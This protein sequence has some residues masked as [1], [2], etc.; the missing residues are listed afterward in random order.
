MELRRLQLQNFRN[1]ASLDL[2][3]GAGMHV[4]AGANAQGKTN[5]LEAVYFAATGR[6]PRARHESE[7]IDW[8]ADTARVVADYLGAARGPFTVEAALGRR[9]AGQQGHQ[10]VRVQKKFRVNGVART[11]GDLAGLVP[12]VLF[13]VDDLE[14][15]RG[16]PA[17][18]REFLDTDLATMSRTYAWALRQ[19]TRVI[20]QRNKLLKDIREGSLCP[21]CLPAWNE[22]VA[23][24]GGRLL[25]VR[26]RFVRD[27]NSVTGETYQGLTASGQQMTLEYRREWGDPEETPETRADFTFLLAA[28]LAGAEKEEIARGSSLAGPHRDDLRILVDGRDLRQFGSQGEQRTAA[29]ALRVAEF[30]LQNRLLSEPPVLLLDDILSELDRTRRAALLAHLAPM[31]QVIV[32]TTDVDALGLPPHADVHQ[33]CVCGGGVVG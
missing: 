20:E 10:P 29:L 26:A 6:S 31:A 15:I 2:P 18:R 7:L 23:D 27:L 13:L 16:E 28:A 5:L 11:P 30:E 25:E 24:Y 8:G 12:V 1:Y 32:T 22:Q 33:Y 4:F 9:E 17:R 19:Y 14:I 21:D 3:M